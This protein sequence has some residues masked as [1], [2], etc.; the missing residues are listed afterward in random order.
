MHYRLDRTGFPVAVELRTRQ[1]LLQQHA[2]FQH[3]SMRIQLL[4][5]FGET[6]CGS[7]ELGRDCCQHPRFPSFTAISILYSLFPIP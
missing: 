5:V 2:I 7:A 6:R 4:V 1:L 3:W